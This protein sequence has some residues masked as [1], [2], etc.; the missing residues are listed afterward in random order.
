M[1][2]RPRAAIGRTEQG[3]DVPL[4]VEV[5]ALLF[6][7]DCLIESVGRLLSANPWQLFL[8][9]FLLFYGHLALKRRI[10]ELAPPLP[11]T[12]A[13]NPSVMNEVAIA[14]GQGRQVWLA[15]DLD[16]RYVASLA[17]TIGA[18][19]HFV[20]DAGANP[21][22]QARADVLVNAFGQGGFDYIGNDT[23]DLD[24]WK[25]ARLAICVNPS[26]RLARRVRELDRD[27]RFLAKRDGSPY[28]Y[29][30]ALR[31]RQWIKN[32]L[33]F[34]PLLAAHANDVSLYFAA[35][36]L[37][38]AFSACASWGYL[39][40]DLFDLP[41]DRQHETK[42]NRPIAAGAI[43]LGPVLCVGTLL[44]IGGLV[45]AGLLSAEAAGYVA[46]YMLLTILY[47]LWLKRSALVDVIALAM[48]FT[49][50]IL[51]G[52]AIAEITLTPWFLSF[53]IFTFLALGMMKRLG[54]YRSLGASG[55]TAFIG[56]A[57]RT[58]DLPT[59]IAIGAASSFASA[60][61][62]TLY[63]HS[64]DVVARYSNPDY[65]W[66][67]CPLLIYALGRMLL[68]ANRGTFDDPVA[69]AMRDVRGWVVGLA[70]LAVLVAAL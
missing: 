11:A 34:A 21:D 47:S 40:N 16:A 51:A 10:A 23:G 53:C 59:M 33:V 6:S 52:A 20:P 38:V 29:L 62:F 41:H 26:A 13:L 15:S 43:P 1:T 8:L 50:R 67:V 58:E 17:A 27:V 28:D 45:L 55:S 32:T 18:T 56:R 35:G 9:P 36:G 68:L 25:S 14:L 60:I 12:P 5:D 57:Y 69:F 37:F 24:A 42:R 2:S 63:I 7:G 22:G 48:M 4:V 19:G 49:I 30:S 64:A 31:P 3:A 46:F 39:L 61:V 54:E 44:A 65:L 70:A 66:F